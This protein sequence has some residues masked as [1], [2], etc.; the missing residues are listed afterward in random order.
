MIFFLINNIRFAIETLLFSIIF[1]LSTEDCYSSNFSLYAS[2]FSRAENDDRLKLQLKDMGLEF[3]WPTG[4]LKQ[5]LPELSGSSCSEPTTCSM[6]FAEVISSLVEE[7][8]IPEAKVGLASGVSAFL[9]LYT[10]IQG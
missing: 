2:F 5:M 8:H 9:W 7:Q 6:E 4:R 1:L 10:S 3:S